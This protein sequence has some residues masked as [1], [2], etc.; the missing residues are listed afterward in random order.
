MRL[1]IRTYFEILIIILLA[2]LRYTVSFPTFLFAEILQLLVI[3]IKL[4]IIGFHLV[5]AKQLKTFL[6]IWAVILIWI[7]S[8]H[9]PLRINANNRVS[10]ELGWSFPRLHRLCRA[11]IRYLQL[12]LRI[13]N[14]VKPLSRLIGL[15][16]SIGKLKCFIQWE[17]EVD[18]A[19]LHWFLA[20]VKTSL[21]SLRWWED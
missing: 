6:Y 3:L 12:I 1:L 13:R 16:Y 15:T 4:S 20:D 21:S 11:Q 18:S 10:A 17:S 7:R 8:V 9:L 14:K 5:R 2:M 19:S